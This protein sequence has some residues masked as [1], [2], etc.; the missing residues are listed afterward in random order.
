MFISPECSFIIPT[1]NRGWVLREAIDSVLAQDYKN[2]ELI[3]VDDGSTDDT[4]EIL[5]AYRR[6][7][8]VLRQANKGVSAARNRGIAHTQG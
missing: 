5:A 4:R 7:I 2:Y 8:I 3:V 6:D 1:C